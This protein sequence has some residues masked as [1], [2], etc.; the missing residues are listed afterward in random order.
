[1]QE[2][3]RYAG[4]GVLTMQEVVRVGRVGEVGEG[5]VH[6]VRGGARVENG[7]HG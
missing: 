3:E 4:A 7:T 1:M 5:R 2:A 6:R